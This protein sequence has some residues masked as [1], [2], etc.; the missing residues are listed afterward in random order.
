MPKKRVTVRDL[1]AH[2]GVNVS[3]VSRA[4]NPETRNMITPE[5]VKKVVKAAKDLGYVPNRVAAALASNR[6]HTIGVLIPDLMNPVFPPILRG[7]QDTCDKANYTL[8][9]SSSD[10]RAEYERSAL[11]KM[12]ERAVDG[13]VMATARRED[14]LI[15]DCIKQKLPFVLINR[16]VD[17]DGV[18]AIVNDDAAGIR[19]AVEHL[20]SLN[21]EHIAHIAGPQHTS[22][23]FTRHEEFLSRIHLK[24]LS[25]VHVSETKT[26]SIEA[27]KVAM[28]ELLARGKKI[29]AVV[30]SNDLLALGCLDAMKEHDLR[31]PEDISTVG[32]N[33]IPFLDRMTP[34]L[35]TLAIPH[36]EIGVYAAENLLLQIRNPDK[37]PLVIKLQPKLIVRNSTAAP[38]I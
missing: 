8:I 33:N 11:R 16:T 32:F 23:G 20:V 13:F 4:L 37:E 2:V 6:S 1:A 34:A 24:G 28:N 18:N 21:H 17:R 38:S 7:L 27:G 35:T 5:V 22:T 19:M 3:T 12:R 14:P 36:Y 9:S 31:C 25:T 30:A 10:N 15:D 29:T 26:F